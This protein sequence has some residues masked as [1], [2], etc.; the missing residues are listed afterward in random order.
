MA[1]ALLGFVALSRGLAEAGAPGVFGAV[2]G[3]TFAILLGIALFALG[4]VEVAIGVGALRLDPLAWT[5]GAVWCYASAGTNAISFFALP[6]SG[7]LGALVGMAIAGVVLYLLY[8]DEVKTAFGKQA[9]PT[10]AFLSAIVG[11]IEEPAE[12]PRG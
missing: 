2:F 1:S 12:T 11:A 10:P 8:T 6:G 4:A 3:G 7:F 5:A 9:S